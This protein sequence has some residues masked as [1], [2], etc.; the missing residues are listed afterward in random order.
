MIMTVASIKCQLTPVFSLFRFYDW[1]KK[2]CQKKWININPRE[3]FA[4]VAAAVVVDVSLVVVVAA[5]NRQK[6][7]PVVIL[8]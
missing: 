2:S 5:T 6:T 1:D 4:V 3:M 8:N 7:K